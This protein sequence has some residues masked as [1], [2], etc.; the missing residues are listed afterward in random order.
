MEDDDLRWTWR[1]NQYG[2]PGEDELIEPPR[3]VSYVPMMTADKIE[4]AL[5]ARRAPSTPTPVPK[6]WARKLGRRADRREI[7]RTVLL[8]VVS[9][10]IIAGMWPKH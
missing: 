5:A 10:A 3:T 1:D 7:V 2:G 6:S 9:L 8:G 4:A